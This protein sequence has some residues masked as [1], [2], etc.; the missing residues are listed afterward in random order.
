MKRTTLIQV[1]IVG[2]LFTIRARSSFH[3]P[4]CHSLGHSA[5]LIGLELL[6]PGHRVGTAPDK[7]G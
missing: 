5:G 3:F 4:C 2:G 7:L 6:N 1:V